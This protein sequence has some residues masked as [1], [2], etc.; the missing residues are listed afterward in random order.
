MT[1]PCLHILYVNTV[2][3]VLL[4]SVHTHIPLTLIAYADPIHILCMEYPVIS[5]LIAWTLSLRLC[6]HSSRLCPFDSIPLVA[7]YFTPC[8]A[9]PGN[10][11]ITQSASIK[12]RKHLSSWSSPSLILLGFHILHSL[13]LAFHCPYQEIYTPPTIN[14]QDNHRSSTIQH[15]HRQMRITVSIF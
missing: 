6:F 14:T 3:T 7:T 10:Y 1:I 11:S 5:P 15:K 13:S 12:Q 8:M 9:W 2:C 4:H